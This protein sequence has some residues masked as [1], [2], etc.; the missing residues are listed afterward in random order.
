[1]APTTSLKGFAIGALIMEIF[2][3][4]IFSLTQG[5]SQNMSLLDFNGLI[6]TFYLVFLLL[7]GK[8]NII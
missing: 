1:M 2:F 3:A 4:I 8:T 7:I 6:S 5:Y